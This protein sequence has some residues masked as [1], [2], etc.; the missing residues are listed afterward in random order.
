MPAWKVDFPLGTLLCRANAVSI[1]TGNEL[2]TQHIHALPCRAPELLGGSAKVAGWAA[3]VWAFGAIL[4]HLLSGEVPYQGCGN[5]QQLLVASCVE[6]TMPLLPAD[7]QV[8]DS[9]VWDWLHGLLCLRRALLRLL[10]CIC[11]NERQRLGP[12]WVEDP[13][14]HLLQILHRCLLWVS[15]ALPPGNALQGG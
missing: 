12:G 7:P 14:K 9:R 4:V 1:M 11:C 3:D 10:T 6:R 8:P 15:A 2:F 5:L 13:C